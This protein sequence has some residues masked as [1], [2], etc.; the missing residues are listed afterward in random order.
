M[1]TKEQLNAIDKR[2]GAQLRARRHKLKLSQDQLA[3]DCGITF[4]QIQKYEHGTNRISASRLAQFGQVLGVP[5]SYFYG[6]IPKSDPLSREIG[7]TGAAV[8][9]AKLFDA[10]NKDEQRLIKRAISGFGRPAR[11]RSGANAN[12]P[13]RD[14]A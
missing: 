14:A 4:Q 12:T 1:L 11:A 3:K 10:C 8:G 6:E 7:L 5:I 2:V 13:H 9:V